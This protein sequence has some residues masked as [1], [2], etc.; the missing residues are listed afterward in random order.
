MDKYAATI[1]VE[2]VAANGWSLIVVATMCHFSFSRLVL[3]TQ[4]VVDGLYGVECIEWDFHKNGVPIAHSSIPKAR[5]FQCFQFAAALTLAADEAGVVVNV[6]GQ[7][8]V[9]AFIVAGGTNQVNWV[10]M[11]TLGKHLDILGV[12]LVY[13]A[14]FQYL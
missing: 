8:E 4:Q 1:S 5:Q 7:M 14:R 10:E 13:L 12:G 6:V 9:V 11:C 3:R 2:I